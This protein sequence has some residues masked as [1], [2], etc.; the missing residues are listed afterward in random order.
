MD[1][2]LICDLPGQNQSSYFSSEPGEHQSEE[3][4]QSLSEPST[5]IAS[6]QQN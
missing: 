6:Q 2:V 3:P 1:P 5:N 4:S